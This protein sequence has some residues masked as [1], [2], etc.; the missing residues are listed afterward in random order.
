MFFYA[1]LGIL[2]TGYVGLFLFCARRWKRIPA[3]FHGSDTDTGISIVVPFRNEAERLPFLLGWLHSQAYDGPF[4]VLLVDDHSEDGSA[5]ICRSYIDRK[6]PVD[7]RLLPA[8]GKGKK[9]ALSTG[10]RAAR[11]PWI[12]ST[13]ADCTGTPHWVQRMAAASGDDIHMVSGPVRFRSEPAWQRD[14]QQVESAGLIAIGACSLNAGLPT[15]CNGAN[16]MFRKS[17]WEAVNGYAGHAQLASGDDELLMHALDRQFPG[18]I[19][20]Q[21]VQDACVETAP[22]TDWQQFLEQRKRWL[23]KGHAHPARV[24]TLRLGIGLFYAVLVLSFFIVPW[25][26][27]WKALGWPCTAVLLKT[28][29]E[30]FFY[31]SILPFFRLQASWFQLLSWQPLQLLYPLLVALRPGSKR[32]SWKNRHYF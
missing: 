24:K 11:F 14:F 5:E 6:A 30:Y 2:A 4:E 1:V 32:F 7:W 13:D 19:V 12:L 15:L 22:Q 16:L 28:S 3:R 23:S 17:A 31:R 10:I 8:D 29:A 26:D 9:A 25:M 21:K 18:S 27:G 20:F